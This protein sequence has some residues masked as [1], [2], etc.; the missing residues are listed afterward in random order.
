MIYKTSSYK[1]VVGLKRNN[2]GKERVWQGAQEVYPD[3]KQDG[4][5]RLGWEG[6]MTQAG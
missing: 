2:A 4:Q 6:R 1:S 3:L 5:G